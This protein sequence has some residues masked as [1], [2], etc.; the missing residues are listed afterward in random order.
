MCM[1]FCVKGSGLLFLCCAQCV[2]LRN[3]ATVRIRVKVGPGSGL[4]QRFANCTCAIPN[5]RSVGPYLWNCAHWVIARNTYTCRAYSSRWNNPIREW[6]S[7]KHRKISRTLRISH[8]VNRYHKSISSFWLL[9]LNARLSAAS[10]TLWTSVSMKALPI[11][12][13]VTDRLWSTCVK[14]TRV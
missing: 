7:S 8:D 14:I 9:R 12:V 4:G 2:S 13:T 5:L 10:Q 6:V 3:L 1:L 11:H